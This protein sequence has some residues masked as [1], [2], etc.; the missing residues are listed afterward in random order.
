VELIER[1]E[2]D[3]AQALLEPGYQQDRGNLQYAFNLGRVAYA[4]KQYTKAEEYTRQ[5]IALNPNMGESYVSLGMIQLK[6]NRPVDAQQSLQKAVELN[7]YDQ[8]YHTSYGIVLEVNGD[9]PA[10]M[11]QFDAAL[12]L[13]PGEGLTQREMARCRASAASSGPGRSALKP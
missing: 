13:N 10:A 3:Q 8:R 11:A 5:A 4:K 1:G 9:C 7:P 12:A 6:E 2:I